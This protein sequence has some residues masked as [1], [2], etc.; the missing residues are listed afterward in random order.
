MNKSLEDEYWVFYAAVAILPALM[1]VGT[2]LLYSITGKNP[3]LL[4]L[5]VAFHLAFNH[6]ASIFDV[7]D[8]SHAI[9]IAIALAVLSCALALLDHIISGTQ[10]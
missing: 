1:H 8:R 7:Y 2:A 10:Y 9:A 5:G 3:I 6:A 4:V